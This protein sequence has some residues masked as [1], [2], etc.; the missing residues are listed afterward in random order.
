MWA[1]TV[2]AGWLS[3][4]SLA[5]VSP[6]PRPGDLC[7]K[8]RVNVITPEDL[9]VWVVW[10]SAHSLAAVPR[11]STPDLHTQTHPD[12]YQA[13]L[14]AQHSQTY[15]S[16]TQP[17]RSLAGKLKA[18]FSLARKCV[19]KTAYTHPACLYALASSDRR[20]ALAR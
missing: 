12:G 8:A 20:V 4:R 9:C 10:L 14:S 5:A 7:Y 18:C 19:E 2:W 3:A 16:S 11:C 6:Y 1:C 13:W 15:S 17:K